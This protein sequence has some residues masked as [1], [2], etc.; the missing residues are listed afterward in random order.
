MPQPEAKFKTKLK[1]GF[2]KFYNSQP[3]FYFAIVASMMQMAG[4][5]DIFVAAEGHSTWIEAKAG[6]GKLRPT[7]KVVIPRMQQAGVRVVI[8]NADMAADKKE[9]TVCLST[10]TGTVL[11]DHAFFRWADMSDHL[12]WRTVL[13]IYAR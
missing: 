10:W 2:E 8:L 5:P 7:Q 12:F 6:E 4:V 9:R 13:G 3:H 11:L 1:E